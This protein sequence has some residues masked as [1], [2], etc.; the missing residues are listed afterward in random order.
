MSMQTEQEILHDCLAEKANYAA[1]VAAASIV[2][3][4]VC[5]RSESRTQT[6]RLGPGIAAVC[7]AI[8]SGAVGFSGYIAT[9]AAGS[10]LL[11]GFL[12]ISE[13]LDALSN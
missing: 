9:A 3:L 10:I 13:R 2:R 6:L 7:N 8:Y 11:G 5:K 4:G 12:Q 1:W